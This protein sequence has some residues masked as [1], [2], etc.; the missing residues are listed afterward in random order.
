[1]HVIV[2]SFSK[3][4]YKNILAQFSYHTRFLVVVGMEQTTSRLR[5]TFHYPTENDP[6]DD[7]PE[8][9]DEDGK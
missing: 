2:T 1:M 9:L 8:A 4:T 7:L 3:I 5:K 6:E